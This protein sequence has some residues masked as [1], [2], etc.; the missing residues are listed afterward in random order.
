MIHYHFKPLNEEQE[1]VV[2]LIKDLKKP[3]VFGL[4]G[5][6][7]VGKTFTILR[8]VSDFKTKDVIFLAPTNKVAKN[9]RS[10]MSE[11]GYLIE[12]KTIDSFFSLRMRKDYENNTIAERTIP[13]NIPKIIVIDECSM[14]ND[15]QFELID[16]IKED[17]TIILLG[18]DK[19][20]APINEGSERI[21]ISKIFNIINR[22]VELKQQQRQDEGKLK[23][24][25]YGVRNNLYSI[26]H[27]L[28]QRAIQKYSSTSQD[29]RF[30]DSN[31]V[32]LNNSEFVKVLRDEDVKIVAF[33][34]ATVNLL[35]YMRGVA[36]TGNRN[37][38][39]NEILEG[40]RCYFLTSYLRKSDSKDLKKY[41]EDEVSTKFY[42]SDEVT[43]A[44][45]STKNVVDEFT[46]VGRIEYREFMYGLANGKNEYIY[47][48]FP[49]DLKRIASKVYNLRSQLK[50][51][52]SKENKKGLEKLN[53]WYA[54]LKRSSASI[55]KDYG[56]TAHKSQGSTYH[57]VMIPYSDFMMRS[58]VSENIGNNIFY[59]AISRP[60]NTIYFLN[61]STS[62]GKTKPSRN[63]TTEERE[64]IASKT[65]FKCPYCSN[66]MMLGNY[67][68]HHI[69]PVTDEKCTNKE[70]NLQALCRDCH[71]YIHQN[72]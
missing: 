40:D 69:I 39:L 29:I 7:G 54:D 49:E 57:S 17:K 66:D 67:D 28:I 25:I 44:S 43:I 47:K 71:K 32:N 34:N 19:Q 31:E 58:D 63:F 16:S 35:S 15:A 38:K 27:N 22:S 18:D 11:N 24:F 51:N 10:A 50:K 37:F 20:I 56:I 9:L 55:M 62:I 3:E 42:T 33:K 21:G 8:A 30:F 48:I 70:E 13:V 52:L 68:I 14:I 2:N 41:Q 60:K 5:A 6:G 64:Y 61:M 46:P 59:T 26:N 4:I 45:I 23:D 72:K 36:I 65:D 12:C 53:N 1:S